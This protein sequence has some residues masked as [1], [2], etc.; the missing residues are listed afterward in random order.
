MNNDMKSLQYISRNNSFNK[1]IG[2]RSFN[3]TPYLQDKVENKRS[4]SSHLGEIKYYSFKYGYRCHHKPILSM[5]K[6]PFT[7]KNGITY[8]SPYNKSI[9]FN[10]G[11]NN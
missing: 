3:L 2:V 10:R 1:S 5:V 11:G 9:K 4:F 7:V 8:L 6:S